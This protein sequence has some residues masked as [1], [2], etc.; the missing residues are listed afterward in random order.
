[1]KQIEELAKQG[2]KEQAQQLLSQLNDMLNNLQMRQAQGKN[3]QGDQMKQQMDKLGDL[4]RRQQKMM[5]ET[6]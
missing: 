2:S 4:M 3:G 5:N 1:L 6:H